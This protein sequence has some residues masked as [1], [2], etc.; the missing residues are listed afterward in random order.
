M[1]QIYDFL[2]DCGFY[3]LLTIDGE[4]PSGR[5]ISQILEKDGSLYFGTRAD[6]AMHRQLT[7]NNHAALIGF[8]KGRW[9]RLYANVFETKNMTTREQYLSRIPHEIER[10]GSAENPALIVYELQVVKAAIHSPDDQVEIIF[11]E[12]KNKNF[13]TVYFSILTLETAASEKGEN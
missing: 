7:E 11:S 5:P 10:F 4:Y 13:F 3:Y 8:N 6:K 12:K 9:L 2:K 1:S